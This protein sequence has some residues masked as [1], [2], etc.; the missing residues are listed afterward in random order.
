M[1]VQVIR[2]TS[3]FLTRRAISHCPQIRHHCE[4]SQDLG[5]RLKHPLDGER[6]HQKGKGSSLT[7]SPL[8]KVST[9]LHP[10]GFLQ[11]KKR[12][13]GGHPAHPALQD[14]SPEAHSSPAHGNHWGNPQ[15]PTTGIRQTQKWGRPYINQHSDLGGAT[16]A[17]IP[18]SCFCTSAEWSQ[19]PCLTRELSWQFC[20]IY[21]HSQQAIPA[22]EPSLRPHQ[23]RE[24]NSQSH[25]TV[26]HGLQSRQTRKPGQRTW[27]AAEPITSPLRQGAKRAAVPK[28]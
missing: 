8:S 23:V 21:V 11:W 27:I 25:P 19:W 20:L 3:V 17:K 4:K 22:V 15:G 14:T 18:T 2:D 10:E 13:Q 9:A 7:T 26:E 1:V 28:H 24:P 12:A 6:Q 5:V 16:G